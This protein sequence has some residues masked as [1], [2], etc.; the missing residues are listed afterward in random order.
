[1]PWVDF[2]Q[3]LKDIR[4]GGATR[5]G[6][7]FDVNGRVYALEGG[8]RLYPLS[9]EGL[10]EIGRG[11]YRALGM[12]NDW[13]LTEMAEV[14]L[15]RARIREDERAVARQIWRALHIWRQEHG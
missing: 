6:N 13:G 10:V 3:D 12:Y 9:G 2:G 1:M 11:A 14:R 8:G 15:A 5:D 7:R 4:A